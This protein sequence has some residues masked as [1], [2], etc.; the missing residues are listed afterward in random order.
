MDIDLPRV[1]PSLHCHGDQ[2][3]RDERRTP[4]RHSRAGL[5]LCRL[6]GHPLPPKYDRGRLTRVLPTPTIVA[7]RV[8]L[9][10]RRLLV[11][12][13]VLGV[14][15]QP[16]LAPEHLHEA[17]SD[18]GGSAVVHRHADAHDIAPDRVGHEH[19]QTLR[20]IDSPFTAPEPAS[21]V[22][23]DDQ[24][25]FHDLLILRQQ[26]ASRRPLPRIR[27]SGHDPPPSATLHG[28][29]APPLLVA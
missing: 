6:E 11:S 24:G 14:L 1:T 27:V 4:T 2:Q 20:R 23:P 3:Q 10:S 21:E 7:V 25:T 12:V 29:H 18:D 17:H 16:S 19:G 9:V 15:S 8:W 22:G 13:A 5:W 26:E 28:P